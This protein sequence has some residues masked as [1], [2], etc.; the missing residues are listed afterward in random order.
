MDITLYCALNVSPDIACT[1]AVIGTEIFY[2][3]CH[4]NLTG[5][6][7]NNTLQTL[8]RSFPFPGSFSELPTSLLLFIGYTPMNTAPKHTSSLRDSRTV[9]MVIIWP[10]MRYSDGKKVETLP[11]Y[12]GITV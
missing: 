9:N 11:I 5:M 4:N 6:N 10:N 3:S 2:D 7:D 8:S 12:G 1:R